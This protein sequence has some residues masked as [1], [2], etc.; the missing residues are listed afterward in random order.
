MAPVAL[1][2]MKILHPTEFKIPIYTQWGMLGVMIIIFLVIPE[3]PCKSR[4]QIML[5]QGWL[6]SRGRCADAEKVLRLTKGGLANYSVESE[7]AIME[8]TVNEERETA[9]RSGVKSFEVFR[10]TNLWRFLIAG[11]PKIAQQFVGL[12]VFNTYATY[13]CTS[14]RQGYLANISPVGW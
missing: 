12:S 3:S 8:A 4:R 6:V 10:G 13:F 14:C 5:T 11:W 9:E 1:Q 7:I 2:E